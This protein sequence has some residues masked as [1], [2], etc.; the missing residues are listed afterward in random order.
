MV[1]Q[2]G[3]LIE[4]QEIVDMGGEFTPTYIIGEELETDAE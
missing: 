3:V 2:A 1:S 4:D